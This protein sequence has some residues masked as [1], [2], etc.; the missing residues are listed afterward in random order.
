M[1]TELDRIDTQKAIDREERGE[2]LC[3]CE[4]SVPSETIIM[5]KS[6]GHLWCNNCKSVAH[7]TDDGDLYCGPYC[8]ETALNKAEA[9]LNN[10]GRRIADM[11]EYTK[12]D[13]DPGSANVSVQEMSYFLAEQVGKYTG[14]LGTLNQY[15]IE[16]KLFL[17]KSG[18][19]TFK[20]KEDRGKKENRKKDNRPWGY[21]EEKDRI[22][23][24]SGE[25]SF[26]DNAGSGVTGN[27]NF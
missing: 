20:R 26:G 4:L 2:E 19:Y 23:I 18:T 1:T 27:G 7:I 16:I 10:I 24:D 11:Q 8:L 5:C 14:M 17:S 25:N 21:K 9:T 22:G 13:P 3:D 6:C 12:A 15:L